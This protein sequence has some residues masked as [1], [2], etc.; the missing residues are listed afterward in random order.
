MEGP[1]GVRQ[2]ARSASIANNGMQY[3]CG[4]HAFKTRR[5]SKSDVTYVYS[6]PSRTFHTVNC[7]KDIRGE[8]CHSTMA[9]GAGPTPP[10]GG[11][12]RCLSPCIRDR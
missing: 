11:R 3:Y 12:R 8:T 7:A 10:L 9:R 2:L 4:T 6:F 1:V 5:S